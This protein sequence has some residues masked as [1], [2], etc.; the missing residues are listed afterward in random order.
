MPE[1]VPPWLKAMQNGSLGEAR[2]KA[3]LMDRFWILERSVDIEGADL[4]IQRRL[5]GKNLLDPTPPRLGF[6]QV[7]FFESEKTSQTVPSAYILDQEGKAREDFFLL[8]HTGYEENAKIFFL[9]ADM[10]QS[11]FELTEISGVKKYKIPGAKVFSNE[12]YTIK[13]SSNTLS[14]IERRLELVDFKKNREFISW[15]LPNVIADTSA[16]L[17]DY[18][19]DI[20]NS[21]GN[22][23]NEF[24]RI[25][26]N[27][28]K[29]M[30]DIEKMYIELKEIAE[31]ID[32]M[33]AFVKIEYFSHQY[34]NNSYGRWGNDIINNLY[35]E[36]FY[37]TCKNHKDKVET[38]RQDGLLDEYINAKSVIT[39]NVMN[40]LAEKLPIDKNTIHS[41]IIEFS[42]VNFKIES[43]RHRLINATE[44]FN[45]PDTLNKFGHV[46]ISHCD[47][48]GIK[49]ISEN[50]FEFYWLAGRIYI[51]KKQESNLVDFYRSIMYTVC[52]DCLDK[53]YDLKYLI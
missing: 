52:R 15:K 43:V 34:G 41:M 30:Q 33:E 36:G 51:D 1:I 18:R 47:Y 35:D 6:V 50:T 22:I 25:K 9:T 13:S 8:F 42:I 4:I 26:E 28:L 21:W 32:P 38:L 19:E 39:E 11:D 46:E 5:T 53:M 49:T 24:Q 12:K 17:S 3:F 44:Y 7:K 10:V 29:A 45:V 20:T 40:Y 31:E 48:S 37:Y 16:I 14:R 23:P 2:A 27:A